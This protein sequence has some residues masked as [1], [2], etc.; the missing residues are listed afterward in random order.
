MDVVPQPVAAPPPGEVAADLW[1]H[2]EATLPAPAPVVSP[3]PG[4]AAIVDQPAFVAS[5]TGPR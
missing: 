1:S 4:R 5:A 3:P 2:V